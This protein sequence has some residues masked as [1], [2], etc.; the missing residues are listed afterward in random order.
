MQPTGGTNKNKTLQLNGMRIFHC[1]KHTTVGG[2]AGEVITIAGVE[3]TDMAFVTL[4][5][6]GTS[7]VELMSGACS[8]NTLTVTF[9]ENPLADT[10][11]DVLILRP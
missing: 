7:D 10:I 4:V 1:G 6:D 11:I 2:A 9:S 8:A 3:A 5:N